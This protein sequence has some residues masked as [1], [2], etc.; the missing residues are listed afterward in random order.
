MKLSEWKEIL[1]INRTGYFENCSYTPSRVKYILVSYNKDIGTDIIGWENNMFPA[2]TCDMNHCAPISLERLEAHKRVM[3]YRKY[4]YEKYCMKYIIMPNKTR[5]Y[6]KR[7][8]RCK[9]IKSLIAW[10]Y[11]GEKKK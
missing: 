9:R 3:Y 1:K 10:D 11:F 2:A 4:G 7:L 8:Q 6:D 5:W